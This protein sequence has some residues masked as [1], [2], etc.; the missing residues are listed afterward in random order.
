MMTKRQKEN[1][2][3]IEADLKNFQYVLNKDFFELAN[4]KVNVG[5][6][7]ISIKK[8]YENHL[9]EILRRLDEVLK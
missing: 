4:K 5:G 3:R 9:K 2:K 7:E 6:F 8:S 1:L